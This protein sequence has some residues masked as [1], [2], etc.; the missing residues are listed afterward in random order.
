MNGYSMITAVVRR[1]QDQDYI[2]FFQRNGAGVVLGSLCEGSARKKLLDMLG[3]ERK[4]KVMLHCVLPS[5]LRPRILRHLRTEMH[6]DAPNNGI[7]YFIS[8]ECIGGASALRY[9]YTEDTII[10]NEVKDMKE[11][12]H[13]LIVAI[14]E[15][16]HTGMVM[17]AAREAGATGG[18]IVRAKGALNESR[19]K[20]FGVSIAE[21]KDVVY[22]VASADKRNDIMSAI[23]NKAGVKSPAHTIKY[24]GVRSLPGALNSFWIT[25]RAVSA[26]G[27]LSFA[28][29]AIII[30]ASPII[31]AAH[32]ISHAAVFLVISISSFFI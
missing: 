25:N 16:G 30:T 9:L 24:Q 1:D 5:A 18:T 27:F 6:I 19:A 4:E 2:D 17:D 32:A 11:A 8:L 31:S 14:T 29:A 21:E 15:Q 28:R 12:K 3:L 23:M 10:G 13:S 7:A 20:F 26:E 22:I